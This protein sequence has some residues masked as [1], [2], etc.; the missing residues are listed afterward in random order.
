MDMSE[1]QIIKQLVAA[2]E[3]LQRPALPVA[4]DLWDTSLV[5]AYLKRSVD[6]VRKEIIPLPSFPKPIRLPVAGRAQ[7][8]YRARDVIA[9]AESHQLKS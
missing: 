1:S 2:I 3:K 8:L 5:A 4:V 6:N 9:W 7:A